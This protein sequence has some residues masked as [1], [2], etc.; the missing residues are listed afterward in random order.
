[1]NVRTELK[2]FEQINTKFV[3]KFSHNHKTKFFRFKLEFIF[4]KL[5]YNEV[6]NDFFI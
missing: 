6:N 1:M 3:T 5:R 4:L 2:N